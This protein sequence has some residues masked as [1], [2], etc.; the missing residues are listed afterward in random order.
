MKGTTF[1]SFGELKR[2]KRSGKSA[3]NSTTGK[4]AP[5]SI[6]ASTPLSDEEIFEQSMEDVTPLGWS[7]ITSPRAVPVEI[8]NP[9]E[10]E[11]EGLQLLTDFVN[12]RVPIDVVVSGEY[13]EGAP[14][15]RG[16]RWLDSLRTGH[17]AVQAHLDLHGLSILDARDLFEKFIRDCVWR[18]YG[19][20]RIVHGRGQHSTDGLP[21]LKEH[22]QKWLC[23]RRM[24]RHIVAYTSARL[25]DGGGGALYVLLKRKAT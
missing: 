11:D 3:P 22:L 20:V 9:E 19:C 13:V 16:K 14:D 18:A 2:L 7:S 23:S 10:S 17:F 6:Q 15:P 1:H 4:P 25:R 8:S 24:G 21:L 12:G 5:E